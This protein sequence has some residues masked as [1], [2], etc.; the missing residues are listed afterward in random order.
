MSW[1]YYMAKRPNWQGGRS[2]AAARGKILAMNEVEREYRIRLGQLT[3]RERVAMS[4]G[5]L[6]ELCGMIRRQIEQAEPG[7]SEREIRIRVA[8]RLYSTDPGAQRLLALL[9]P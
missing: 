1:V 2:G 6:A 8:Q 4:F 7:L 9:D 3:G 5:M